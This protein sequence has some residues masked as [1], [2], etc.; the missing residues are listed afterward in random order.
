MDTH[1]KEYPMLNELR[2]NNQPGQQ[3]LLENEAV[4]VGR[5]EESDIQISKRQISRQH[6]R[7]FKQDDKF[8]I[9]DLESRNGTW[10]NGHQISAVQP[11]GDGD[12]IQLAL[13][14]RLQFVASGATAPMPFTPPKVI[15]G[16]LRLERDSRRV[17]VGDDELDPALSLPQYRLLE[18]LYV[19]SGSVCTREAVVDTVWPETGGEGVTEQAIDALVRRLRDRLAEIDDHQYIVTVRGHGFRL[20]NPHR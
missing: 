11:L 10:L 18:L 4:T 2:E 17:F 13:V 5:G 16:R 8:F 19:N 14:V 1:E 6:I 3:W 12:E 7:I 20:D 15:G 9:E